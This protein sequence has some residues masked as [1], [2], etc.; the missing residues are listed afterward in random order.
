[1]EDW[2]NRMKTA[3]QAYALTAPVNEAI[4]A[5]EDSQAGNDALRLYDC[6]VPKIKTHS[7]RWG[8]CSNSITQKDILQDM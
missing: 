8:N 3:E 5:M 1:M 6:L 7:F 2:H 4:L